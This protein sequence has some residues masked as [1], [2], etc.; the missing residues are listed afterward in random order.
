MSQFVHLHLH[1]QY[2]VLDGA[3]K[4]HN[5][6]ERAH[7]LGQPAIAVTDHGN[8]HG[9]VE[10]FLAAK[11]TGIKP[12]IG[13]EV[14][15][16]SGNRFDRTPRAQG[17]ARTHHLTLLAQNREGYQNLCKLVSLGYTEGF[18][19]KP[20]VDLDLLKEL[21]GGIIA[22]S[23]CVS[24]EF[25]YFAQNEI[26]ES[27]LA[28]A[29]RYASIFRD[30]YYLEIQP[31]RFAEQLKVNTIAREVGRK[32]GL[33][34][35]ATND[36]HYLNADD[37]HAQEVLMCI[38]TG[39]LITDPDR[40]QHTDAHLHLKTVD[41]M[42][43][44]LPED[45]E[46]IRNTVDI[47][48]RCDLDFDFST[49]HMPHFEPPAEKTLE[50]F[51]TEE[52]RAGLERRFELFR[53]RGEECGP[54][55]EAVY[56]AR[57]EEE[58]SLIL[59][60]GFAG[61]FLV[62]SD[63]IRWAKDRDIPVGPGRGSA[64][65]SLVAYVMSIT[66]LDPIA[67]KLLFER[68]LNPE[69]ISLPD[70][71]IDF[72]IN[73]RDQVI[74]Y[75]SQKY[76]RDK[77]AQICTFGTLKAKAVIKD[78][79]RV[80]GLSY[81]ETDRIAKLIPAPRQGFD[82]PLSEALQMEKRLREY[83]EGEG[84]QLI[85]VALRLEGL[86]RHTSTHA[87]GIVIA[88][89]PIMEY[90]PLMVD[91][92]QQVVTQFSMS[93]V[94]KIGLVKFDFLGLKTLT[95]LREAVRMI[96]DAT[97]EKIDLNAL[98]LNDKKTYQLISSGRS[99]GVFQ[100]ESSGITDM[101]T[102]LKPNC[103]DDL[104]AILALYRPG[105]LDAGMVDHYIN[106]KHKREAVRYQ[107]PM[108]EGI[109]SDTYG[110][111]LYQEQIMQ[112]ARDMAGYSLGDADLLRRAMGKKKPAEMAKQ[113]EIFVRGAKAKGVS[114]S[115]ATEVFD[116]METFARYGF[117]RSHSAAYALISFQT[118][119]L[120]AHYPRFFMAALMTLE[121]DGTDRTLKNLN[122]CSAMDIDV[123][124][125]DVNTGSVGFQVVGKTIVFG[126]AAM[127]G[128]G[129]R[130][131][132]QVI[133]ERKRRGP[134]KGLLDFCARVDSSIVNRRTLEN[135]IKSGA[136]DGSQVT[137]A[138]MMSRLDDV[139]KMAE[140]YKQE[141]QSNQMSLFSA[142]GELPS[143]EKAFANRRTL[144]EFPVNVKLAHEKEALGF[145]LSGHPLEKFRHELDRLGSSTIASVLNR[146]DGAEVRVSG[147][148]TFL[149]LKN[150]KKGDR[151]ATFVLEDMLDT[152]EVIVWPDTYQKAYQVL[153]SEDPILIAGRLDVSDE[154]RL[155]VASTIE[156]AIALRDK[157]A[158][159]AV[160]SVETSHCTPERFES[161][162][163]LLAEHRG[164]VPV[165]LILKEPK[166]SET[167]VML[168]SE[169]RIAPSETLCTR[170]E[171]LFGSPV[172]SFR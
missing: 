152:I 42:L 29:E 50:D 48:Q 105:P 83:A 138:E 56:W 12:I 156:S 41:E 106:R 84:K 153:N 19:F 11:E 92:D 75:V 31:H 140:R 146:N 23:G 8:M 74:E 55:R 70:I 94:E 66:E 63:F 85:D 122:E 91:K 26:F 116:Q 10:F 59:K 129:A 145:Y 151:Y 46:A 78:V 110:I 142:R 76:G 166:H 22:L 62:V 111:I 125:P 21:S 114:D 35:V 71:D 53:S 45:E 87:A 171:E 163:K 162:K 135:F 168:P 38:S 95:V 60:M 52:A 18:Y 17:G 121:M 136:F 30:R 99:I 68:F 150:T 54:E 117:N 80:L 104:V 143:E 20:R 44:E 49:Y 149:R 130:A 96:E 112:I 65:G 67:H 164:E 6:I 103:F 5:V 9:A 172:M 24:S 57:L 81:A 155:I 113:R 36:C 3:N 160:V 25:S 115:V 97:G 118:A 72:C 4:L 61:Y 37:A 73:G 69:R 86:S 141:A 27:A 28:C 64:A 98:P 7:S 148:I 144:G 161:L 131:V 1:T 137:R 123:L 154:R 100:L 58:I 165:K 124:P 33:P 102:R 128:V 147:V 132:E 79:G 170:I 134:F 101:V 119:Y 40:I 13:C 158:K 167:E 90:M 157:T 159:L 51:F 77:V 16:S 14:Y 107:H 89:K 169:L 120:K 47:A 93:Y 139:I 15:V 82:Y 34:L 109:L 39:K 2:S 108:L 133:E 32:L 88:D 127:K 126:L 43:A